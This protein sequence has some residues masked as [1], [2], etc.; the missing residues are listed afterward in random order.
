MEHFI[1]KYIPIRVQHLIGETV[2][3]IASQSQLTRLQNFEMEKYKKLNE[4]VL[5]D[6]SHPELIDLMRKIGTDLT[7]TVSKFKAIAKAKG[8]RYEIAAAKKDAIEKSIL[9]GE[10]V[11]GSKSMEGGGSFF[12]ISN[13]QQSSKEHVSIRSQSVS[14][15]RDSNKQKSLQ[16]SDEEQVYPNGTIMNTDMDE[17]PPI[18][19]VEEE[20]HA[21]DAKP[22]D[23]SDDEEDESAKALNKQALLEWLTVADFTKE[24]QLQNI[25][26]HKFK[27][28]EDELN[29]MIGTE[30]IL[31]ICKVMMYKIGLTYKRMDIYFKELRDEFKANNEKTLGGLRKD[32]SLVN[33]GIQQ[34]HDELERSQEEQRKFH[35]KTIK[36]VTDVVKAH[37]QVIEL[38]TQWQRDIGALAVVTSCIAEFISM[39]TAIDKEAY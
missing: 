5:D 18:R 2:S 29:A 22:A 19:E 10:F 12:S 3:S 21:D 1:D 11:D 7:E 16:D 9:G 8:I 24:I 37:E 13:K 23:F 33:E 34:V 25:A 14:N 32:L 30:G 17:Q 28:D 31:K 39:Q 20:V 38:N 27:L 36:E 26:G 15:Q 35:S 4:D 6:E